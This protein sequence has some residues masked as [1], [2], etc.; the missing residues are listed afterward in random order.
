MSDWSQKQRQPVKSGSRKGECVCVMRTAKKKK[1][2]KET[3]ERENS[4]RLWDR[5]GESDTKKSHWEREKNGVDRK[6]KRESERADK[7]FGVWACAVVGCGLERGET[8]GK[9]HYTSICFT[10]FH[11]N[12]DFSLFF[13]WVKFFFWLFVPIYL[14]PTDI[15]VHECTETVSVCVSVSTVHYMHVRLWCRFLCML[16][17]LRSRKVAQLHPPLKNLAS[18]HEGDFNPQNRTLARTCGWERKLLHNW[19]TYT[20]GDLHI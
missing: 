16:H 7:S 15:C 3:K 1:R 19:N 17:R 2:K 13:S 20:H 18:K 12:L 5:K 10:F 9:E 4:W 14:W 6:K 8:L 11:F